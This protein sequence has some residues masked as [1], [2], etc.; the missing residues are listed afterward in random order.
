MPIKEEVSKNFTGQWQVGLFEA[1][2][3]APHKCCYGCVCICCSA[4]TQR[5]ELLDL[6]GEPYVCFGGLCD[7]CGPLGEPQDR[8]CLFLE[9]CCCPGLA[10]SG[11]RWMVQT[12][13]DRENTPCDDF[14]ITATCLF[15][16]AVQLAQCCFDVP[17]ELEMLADCAVFSVDGCMYAQQQIE[18]E[19]IKKTGYTG[20]PAHIVDCLPPKQ[21]QMLGSGGGGGPMPA[22]YGNPGHGGGG[23]PMYAQSG[24]PQQAAGGIQ[25]QCGACRKIFMSPQ[26]GVTIA[27]PFCG[28]HNQT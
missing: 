20:P 4:Y 10:L 3:Q 17:N 24:P 1:P 2:V 25:V 21:Q 6:T 23:A 12:R 19:H 8:S 27:C 26:A 11:N 28:A 15:Y 22:A 9:V 18:I 14:I 7:G 5:N 13:F 16:Y